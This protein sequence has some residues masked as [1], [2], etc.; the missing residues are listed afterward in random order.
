MFQFKNKD[1]LIKILLF[2]IFIVLYLTNVV[3]FINISIQ[4]K[5]LATELK[6]LNEEL[7]FNSLAK[8]FKSNNNLNVFYKEQGYTNSGTVVL[9]LSKYNTVLAPSSANITKSF[10]TNNNSQAP[11]NITP[12]RWFECLFVQGKIGYCY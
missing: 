4:E 11:S 2:Y 3:F 10:F 12:Q 7:D 8:D 9:D 6:T 5:I 1:H